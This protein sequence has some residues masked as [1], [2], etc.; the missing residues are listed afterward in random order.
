MSL[1]SFS[2]EP[3]GFSV[4]AVAGQAV[5]LLLVSLLIAAGSWMLRPN[6]ISWNADPVSYELELSA[7]LVELA[8]GL[9]LFEEGDH[10]FLDTRRNAADVE[11]TIAYAFILREAS[12]DDDLLALMDE[13]Y[14]ED[15]IL[16][17]GDGE[18]SG[19][20]NVAAKLQQRGYENVSILRV[21][22]KG[23]QK[24]GGPV[25]EPTILEVWDEAG[26]NNE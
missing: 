14:P 12:F 3:S 19:V 10:V 25:S 21:G 17:F 24:D 8:D 4:R 23:W 7:P 20:S 9:L 15:P 1:K 6:P 11:E 13:V 2:S 18:L 26:E 22:V 5:A 16:L